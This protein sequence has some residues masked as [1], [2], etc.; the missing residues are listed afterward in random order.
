MAPSDLIVL[1]IHDAPLKEAFDTL[2]WYIQT[3]GNAKEFTH[4]SVQWWLKLHINELVDF[5]A[6][7]E[8]P[9]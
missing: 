3:P 8:Y 4:P 1:L 6:S 5:I 2:R 7:P 9:R